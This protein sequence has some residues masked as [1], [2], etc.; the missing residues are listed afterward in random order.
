MSSKEVGIEEGRKKLGDLVTAAQYGKTTIVTRNGRPAAM[1]TPVPLHIT[2]RDTSI[3]VIDQG[4]WRDQAVEDWIEAAA[5]QGYGFTPLATYDTGDVLAVLAAD[6]WVD[7][8]LVPG[9]RLTLRIERANE[10]VA[11]G[12]GDMLD[13][14]PGD[15][16]PAQHPVEPDPLDRPASHPGLR[17]R[18]ALAIEAACPDPDTSHVG[19]YCP[20]R[21][22]AKIA[23]DQSL[24]APSPRPRAA[25]ERFPVRLNGSGGISLGWDG[26]EIDMSD[27]D[28]ERLS[29][30]LAQMVIARRQPSL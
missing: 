23:R 10:E 30:A 27:D 28:A 14:H 25:D 12:D 7:D 20:F 8:Q 2:L 26:G 9:V 19:D 1:I 22:A 16:D 21:E 4:N 13:I 6:E 5:E 18:I 3:G 29:S 24:D 17:E 11:E 15:Y